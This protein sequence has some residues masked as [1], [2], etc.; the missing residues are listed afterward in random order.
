MNKCRELDLPTRAD[1]AG[2]RTQLYLSTRLLLSFWLIV[3]EA[4]ICASDMGP[5]SSVSIVL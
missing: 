3:V 5:E 2:K 4:L 1:M